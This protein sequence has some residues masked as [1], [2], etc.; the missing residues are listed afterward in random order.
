MSEI[1]FPIRVGLIGVGNWA[2][3][4]H[5]PIL[6]LL[7]DYR[8]TVVQGRRRAVAAEAARR[9]DIPHVADSA[10]EVAE[11]PE[12]DLVLVL[13]TAPQ[14]EQGIRAALA[15]GKHV[16][17]EWPLTTRTETSEEMLRLAA[18]KG[19]RHVVGLQRRLAPATRFVHDLVSKGYVGK[20]RSARLHVS[21]NYFQA[22][23]EKALA[24]TVPP[25]NFSSVVAIYGG[26]FLDMLFAMVGRPLSISGLAVNQFPEV[27]VEGGET[28]STTTPDQL[29]LTGLL[30]GGA[31]LS[32][33]I[34]GGKRNGSGVQIDITGDA[35]DLR[36]ANK[37]AF[38]DIGEDYVIQ[39][40]H[41][42]NLPLVALTPPASYDW[43]PPSSGL[44][45][46]VEDLGNLF[47][48]LARDFATGSHD[49]PSFA[50]GVWMH[51]L[52]DG[53]VLSS[54]TGRQVVVEERK[55]AA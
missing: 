33:H 30:P 14:H 13:T 20:L 29:V 48:A 9:F 54:E 45:S 32:V 3:R 24:W 2:M 44:P 12:V 47:A 18:A 22:L 27:T 41:G 43:L 16:Y 37:S 51:R 7:P 46:S 38:G 42:D 10:A 26:H 39:G 40:A 21:M 8:V 49:A 36:I 17:S 11:H 31:V 55:H 4:G 15:A 1:T 5:L 19:L 28:L 34:E 50:D 52:L 53:V 35:G 6:Q 23:R 25:E